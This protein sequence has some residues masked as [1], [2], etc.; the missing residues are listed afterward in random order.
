MLT[1]GIETFQNPEK[2]SLPLLEL[3]RTLGASHI[4]I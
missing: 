3:F 1:A 2:K 4:H